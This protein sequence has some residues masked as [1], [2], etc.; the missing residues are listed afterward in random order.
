MNNLEGW[1]G[2]N[3]EKWYEDRAELQDKI[4]TRMR[5]L[6][7]EPVL[8]G[9]SGMVPHDAEERLGMDVSGKGIWN[10]FVRPTFLK[11]TDPQFN[12][13]ADIYYDEL[14][15]VSGVAKYYSMD[16]FHE[17]GSIEGVDLTEA[18]KII[19]G[20]MKRANPEAV[21]VIQGWN[22]NPRAKLLCRHS[23]RRHCGSRPRI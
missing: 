11:S 14:R 12:K 13:I 18:G 8:P 5:E 1:G 22:E 6:G 4:L 3:S 23:Q 2:P 9:Y 19:A 10:G 16:P 20:A 7:M 21:W 17:G 15:K